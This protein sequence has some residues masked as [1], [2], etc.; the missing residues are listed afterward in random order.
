[1]ARIPIRP[2]NPERVCWGCNKY[3][4]ADALRCG[5]GTIRTPHPV[6]LFGEDWME[7]EVDAHDSLPVSGIVSDKPDQEN[8]DMTEADPDAKRN[9][10][11]YEE[12]GQSVT[13]SSALKE[14][15]QASG[16]ITR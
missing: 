9:A 5:N 13:E 11:G 1:M 15:L 7:W 14:G 4:S 3:C 8:A 6:E 16:M 10:S 12:G 2:K